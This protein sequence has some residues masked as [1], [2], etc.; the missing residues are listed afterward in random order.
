MQAKDQGQ[1]GD[2][3]ESAMHTRKIAQRSSSLHSWTKLEEK[4]KTR[5]QPDRRAVS[6]KNNHLFRLHI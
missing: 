2:P 5:L 4:E 6:G 3:A 1:E